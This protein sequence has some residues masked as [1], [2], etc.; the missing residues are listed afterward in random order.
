MYIN[1]FPSGWIYLISDD[2]KYW[3]GCV[4]VVE[5]SVFCFPLIHDKIPPHRDKDR[6]DPTL[7]N[8]ALGSSVEGFMDV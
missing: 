6:S 7:P 8:E 5:I 3:V 2:Q 4:A 1:C